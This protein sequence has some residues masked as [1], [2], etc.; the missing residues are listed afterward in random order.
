[1]GMLWNEANKFFKLTSNCVLDGIGDD[2]FKRNATST[3]SHEGA[4]CNS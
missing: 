1:M 4:R 3:L 2:K